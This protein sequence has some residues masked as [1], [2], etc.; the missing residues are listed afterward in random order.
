MDSRRANIRASEFTSGL[1][2]HELAWAFLRAIHFVADRDPKMANQVL[3]HVIAVQETEWRA[4]ETFLIKQIG[5][6]C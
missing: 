4:R 5:G 6:P 3:D 2:P 1:Q